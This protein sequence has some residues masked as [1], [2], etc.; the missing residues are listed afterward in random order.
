MKTGCKLLKLFKS[1]PQ[2]LKFAHKIY[3]LFFASFSFACSLFAN[4]TEII[5]IWEGEST[6][7]VEVEGVFD[8]MGPGD[9]RIQELPIGG[10]I[11]IAVKTSSGFEVLSDILEI[12]PGYGELIIG[13]NN[14]DIEFSY[15]SFWTGVRI[16]YKNGNKE[17]SNLPQELAELSK[18]NSDL[19]EIARTPELEGGIESLLNSIKESVKSIAPDFK[20]TI[21]CYI[22]ID[23]SGEASYVLFFSSAD[24]NIKSAVRSA[25]TGSNWLPGMN[26]EKNSYGQEISKLR[27]FVVRFTETE[28]L[29]NSKL[30]DFDFSDFEMIPLKSSDI[31]T[32]ALKVQ[33]NGRQ[34][35]VEQANQTELIR[36]CLKL[37]TGLRSRSRKCNIYVRI[38]SPANIV[39]Q[40]PRETLD[41]FTSNGVSMKH[42]VKR[43]IDLKSEI[44]DVCV[45]FTVQEGNELPSGKYI[46]E[47]YGAGELIGESDLH[48]R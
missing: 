6:R 8:E 25:I 18:T 39:L 2:N 1:M 21:N 5:I 47:I 29:S 14:E 9:Y 37:G 40:R 15:L 32:I 24:M 13:L 12:Y 28:N 26:V 22:E 45:F 17:K 11:T 42:S 30:S 36:T 10:P 44:V 3:I 34:S 20:E 23:K 38:I 31:S 35:E 46:I 4:T 41:R 27:S 7:R 16:S 19:F 48:L 43:I 33:S